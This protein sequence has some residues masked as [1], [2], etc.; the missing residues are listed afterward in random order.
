MAVSPGE[1]VGSGPALAL[2]GTTAAVL[3]RA[4]ACGASVGVAANTRAM[5]GEELL[6]TLAPSRLAATNVYGRGSAAR[7]RGVRHRGV[8]GAAVVCG[9]GHCF[10]SW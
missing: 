10:L 8:G 1:T 4:A 3:A 7:R 5:P 2:S 6:E 9:V